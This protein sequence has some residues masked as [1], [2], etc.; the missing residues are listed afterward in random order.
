M[1]YEASASQ[2]RS[3]SATSSACRSLQHIDVA[4]AAEDALAD[5]EAVAD[6]EAVGGF[7]SQHHDAAHAGRAGRLRIPV[8]LVVGNGGDQ[9]P[10]E[11]GDRLRGDEVLAQLGQHGFDL[12]QEG[13]DIGLLQ[14]PHVAEIPVL[15]F[16]QRAVAL[17]PVDESAGPGQQLGVGFAAQPPDDGMA[18]A[19][20]QRCLQGWDELRGNLDQ[21][22][23]DGDQIGLSSAEHFE[24]AEKIAIRVFDDLQVGDLYCW[25]ASKV[26]SC[27][28]PGSGHER[29][30]RAV[31]CG[32]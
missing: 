28:E 15:Q 9:S 4:G 6:A 1:L 30:S 22:R 7:R 27:R 23:I 21:H 32:R 24:Q 19:E 31:R 8:R 17:S 29:F 5:I 12:A 26:A 18:L 25:S 2:V 13:H 3:G 10:V 14:T 16:C 11:A 20:F